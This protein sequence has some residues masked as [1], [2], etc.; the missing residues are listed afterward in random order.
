M[1]DLHL[2][3]TASDGT[4]T[5]EE[6]VERGVRQGVRALALTD[7]DTLSGVSAFLAAC[8]HHG[9]TGIGGIEISAECEEGAGSLHILGYGIDPD[10]PGLQERLA[11]I[12][13]SRDWRNQQ[14]LAK[15]QEMGLELEWNEVEECAGDDVVG[16]IHFAQALINRDYVFSTEEA[17]E[18][19]LGKGGPAY[20]DR[21]RLSSADGIGMI[22][23]AGGVAV[24][25]HPF[26]WMS[27]DAEL[28]AGLRL[29]KQQG[30]AGIEAYYSEYDPE[31]TITLLRLAKKYDL[32]VTGGSDYHGLIKPDLEIGR[33]FGKLCVPDDCLMPLIHRI[34][35]ANAQVVLK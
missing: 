34:G 21:Y 24:M 32:L 16:R 29:L 11:R 9:V 2:H 20:V 8:R 22:R 13:E 4:D 15:L 27:D 35:E 30:L 19:Y 33:G 14:I 28:E 23:E 26:S 3:S 25:A 31:Q 18:Q 17:F 7:H 1:I 6:L 10:H 5:P 12:I